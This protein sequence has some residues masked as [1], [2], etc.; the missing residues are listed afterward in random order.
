MSGLAAVLYGSPDR[1]AGADLQPMLAASAQRAPDGSAA[2]AGDGIALGYLS[3]ETLPG[4][5][6][7]P[8]VDRG[9]RLAIVFD[10]RLDNREDLAAVLGVATET[11]D[12]RFALEAFA[13]W[14]PGAAER[15]L[16]DFA[17]IAWDA[18]R[19]RLV[20]AR[21]Q[22]GSRPLH[23]CV[24]PDLVL[25]AT[26]VAQLLAHPS[27]PREPDLHTVANYLSLDI[28]NA[29]STLLRGINRLPPG[30]VVVF[31][32]GVTSLREYW[33]AEPREALRLRDDREYAERCRELLAR[34]VGARMRSRRPV[35][36]MLSGGLDSSSVVATAA[37]LHA[38][39][40]LALAPFSLVFPGRSEADERPFIEDVAAHHGLAAVLVEPSRVTAPAMREHAARTLDCPAFASDFGTRSL[41]D[42]IRCRGHDVVLTGA[43]GDALF[44]GSV[45][46]YADRLR[47]LRIGAAV[48]QFLADRRTY[49]SGWSRL[50]LIQAGLWPL[51]PLPVK[52]ILR[53]VA[54]RVAGVGGGPPWLRLP[55]APRPPLPGRPRGGSFATED[56]T[57]GLG[58]GLHSLFLE[59][60]E[61]ALAEL[62]LE[63][64]DPLLDVRLVEF[65]LSI[66]E[67]QRRRGPVLKFVLRNALG[68]DLPPSVARRRTKG[69]FGYVIVEALEAL[70]GARF[71]AAAR[72][73]EAGW[74]DGGVLAAAYE[75]T[76]QRF[77][78][79]DPRYSVDVPRLWIAGAI[80]LWFGAVFGGRPP[81]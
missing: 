15:L 64:R 40:G 51:L 80:E 24:Q 41:Y 55:R 70:G 31:E 12:S 18:A 74:V 21:D 78:A 49:R 23:Y 16:G 33:R 73:A 27:T 13:A 35:A 6:S 58:S 1:P 52:R 57:R 29:A 81:A 79:G 10:G 11:S 50:G 14:G 42:A 67:E 34:S 39:R 30:H 76:R 68:Q 22:L 77:A 65:A 72:I 59:A 63:P 26:D 25:C 4:S 69:S 43:G 44:G 71:F 32:D 45:F 53:P 47:E 5:E 9:R 17:W 28:P 56:V 48:R 61:R 54:R 8:L 3:F 62:P 60:G 36:A 38:G 46:Q 66:P 19:R 37:R 2:W 7:Q 75:I 20:A